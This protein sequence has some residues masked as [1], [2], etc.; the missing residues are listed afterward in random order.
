[1]KIFWEK[2]NAINFD[3][4]P[5]TIDKHT[6][7][8]CQYGQHY[9]KKK[10]SKH[11]RLRLQ[12]TRKIGCCAHIEI[13]QYTLY[14]DY[15]VTKQ[16]KEGLSPWK[17]RLLRENKLRELRKEL[18]TGT[19]KIQAKYFVSLPMNEAHKNHPTGAD[20]AFAQKVHPLL[21][22]KISELVSANITDVHEVKKLLKYHTDNQISKE[23]GFKPQAHD[24]VF[25][26]N[27]VDIKNHVYRAKRA[28]ELSKL[29][30]ENL[31][32]KIKE[33]KV[34]DPEST[35]FFRPYI[36]VED[37]SE[38]P[39]S[40]KE[41]KKTEMKK[42][43]GFQGNSGS[44][45][46]WCEV[47]GSHKH[48]S[49]TFLY[50]HQT[51]WQKKLLERYGNNIS[52]I[53]AT[54]KTTRYDL[55][56]FFVCVRTNVGYGVVGEFIT[57]AETAEHISEALQQLRN[58]NPTWNPQFFMTDYS[59][60]ELLALE[61]TF[62]GVQIYLCDFHREQAWERWTNNHKHGLSNDEKESLLS[63]L[64]ECANAPPADH[65]SGFSQDF[66]YQ[67]AVND[68]KASGIWRNNNYVRDWLETKW[69][70]IPKVSTTNNTAP[71]NI[72]CQMSMP[73]C[74][75]AKH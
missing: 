50:I 45:D 36:T 54:Y 48:C 61:Q 6:V 29:D 63:M 75:H 26:P 9:F 56:L 4:T 14:P 32:L 10:E 41:E 62:P 69:L 66:Y 64:R 68:L 8:D 52:L 13:T 46:D 60:A 25:Y 74:M 57:Q 67:K 55:A 35:F 22:T 59:E 51:Q 24:R 58:W 42:M 73:Y 40:P 65:G 49:Q 28:L 17:V 43:N 1:M 44:D 7:L 47:L 12:G 11:A 33:W 2:K 31:R 37:E 23:L 5:F 20:I 38:H 15:Q 21:L 16:E 27:I 39:P 19:P 72:L 71:V 3:D 53:D 34:N 70:C 30:Q 18:D